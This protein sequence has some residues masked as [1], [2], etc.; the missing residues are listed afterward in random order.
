MY[1]NYIIL[2]YKKIIFKN[3]SN[4]VTRKKNGFI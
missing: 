3:N 4:L 2:I 1:N